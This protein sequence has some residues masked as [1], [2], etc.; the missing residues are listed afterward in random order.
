[1]TK[2]A[3]ATDIASVR[4]FDEQVSYLHGII[5]LNRPLSDSGLRTLRASQIRAHRSLKASVAEAEAG[6]RTAD[7]PAWEDQ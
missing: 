2:L 5:T 3:S 6:L 4:A 1:M 7:K